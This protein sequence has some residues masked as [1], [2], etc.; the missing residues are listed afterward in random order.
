MTRD[1]LIKIGKGA[2]IAAG[3]AVIAYLAT[4][5]PE[6]AANYPMIGPAIGAM[7]AVLLNAAR[8]WLASLSS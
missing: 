3:G 4:A 6:V 7:G 2:L 5:I 8:K 1:D